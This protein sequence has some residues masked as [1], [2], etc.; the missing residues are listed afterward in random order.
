MAEETNPINPLDPLGPEYGSMNAPKLDLKSMLPFEG[1]NINPNIVDIPYDPL[2]V[3]SFE[4]RQDF[5]IK[6]K[7]TGHLYKEKPEKNP[8]LD[9]KAFTSALKAKVYNRISANNS[10]DSYARMYSYDAGPSGQNFYKRYAAFGNETFERI[11]F[12]PTRNNEAIYNEGTSWLQRHTRMLQYSAAPL[13]AA[14]FTS[15]PR[16]LMRMLKGDFSTDPADAKIYAEA[17]AIGQDTAGGVG[18]FMNNLSMNFAYTAGIMTEAIVEEAVGALLAAPTGGASFAA[19]TINNARKIP[20]IFRALGKAFKGMTT[21][22]AFNKTLNAANDINTARKM[23]SWAKIEKGVSSKVGRFINPAE[24]TFEAIS[25][26]IKNADNLQGLARAYNTAYKTAGG[27]YRDVRAINMAL[28]EARL[29][30]GFT[31]NEIYNDL[32]REFYDKNGFAPDNDM[33]RDMRKQALE[34]GLDTL[35][36][37]AWLIYLSNKIVFPNIVG[38]RGG[39][40]SFL[41]SKTDDILDLKFGKVKKT[42]VP[43]SEGSKIMTPKYEWVENSFKNTI[44]ETYKQPLRKLLPAMG[45]YFKANVTEGL[46][47]NFQ[48]IIAEA[49]K[50]YYISTFQNPKKDSTEYY[51]GLM[52]T[53]FKEHFQTTGLETFA[54]G[55]FMGFLGGGMNKSF[56]YL[57]QAVNYIKDKDAY[58]EYKAAK[59]TYGAKIA[60]NLSSIDV[61]EFFDNRAFNF[62]EQLGTISQEAL[63]KKVARDQRHKQFVGQLNQVLDHNMMEMFVNHLSSYKDLT[64]EEFQEALGFETIEEATAAQLKIDSTIEKALNVQKRYDSFKERYPDPINTKEMSRLESLGKDSE[65]YQNAQFLNS[66]WRLSRHN[67]VFFG[68]S[69]EDALQRMSKIVNKVVNNGP[70]GDANASDVSILFDPKKMYQ[71][72][73]MLETEIK[74]AEDAGEVNVDI[75]NKRNKL[76]ALKEVIEKGDEYAKY[77][78]TNETL[79]E[80]LFYSYLRL[81]KELTDEELNEEVKKIKEGVDEETII[82]SQNAYENA[83]KNYLKVIGKMSDSD[84]F[85]SQVDESFEDLLDFYKLQDEKQA[86]AKAVNMLNDPESF[87]EHVERNMAWMKQL[88]NNRKDYY[89]DMVNNAM[90]STLANDLINSLASEGIYI[91]A[92]DLENLVNYNILP[93]EFYDDAKKIVIKRNNPRYKE[94]A[95]VLNY[96]IQQKNNPV[97]KSTGSEKLDAK[98]QELDNKMKA[99]LEKLSKEEKRVDLDPVEIKK[100]STITYKALLNKIEPG[101]YVD[102]TYFE[103]GEEI[104]ATFYRTEEGFKF[105]NDQ[106]AVVPLGNRTRISKAQPFELRMVPNEEEAKEVIERYNKLKEEAANQINEEEFEEAPKAPLTTLDAIQ[107]DAPELYKQLQELYEESLGGSEE[108][109]KIEAFE[110]GEGFERFIKINSQARKLINEH[111]AKSAVKKSLGDQEI[112][113]KINYKGVETDVNQIPENELKKVLNTREIYLEGLEKEEEPNINLIATVKREIA[114]IKKVLS[115]LKTSGLTPQQQQVVNELEKLGAQEFDILDG[116]YIIDGDMY[117]RVS[118]IVEKLSGKTYKY[119][120]QDVL[121]TLMLKVFKGK[122]F[123]KK[124]VEELIKAIED[125]V[126]NVSVTSERLSGFEFTDRQGITKDVYDREVK[127]SLEK[128]KEK[129]DAL[130]KSKP[131]APYKEVKQDIINIVAENT[132]EEARIIGNYIDEA[133]RDFFSGVQPKF[134]PAR[135]TQ[136]AY[137]FLFGDITTTD[138]EGNPIKTG[139]LTQLKKLIENEGLYIYSKGI[140]LYDTNTKIAGTI[141][142]ILVDRSGNAYIV[143]VKTGKSS[144]WAHFTKDKLKGLNKTKEELTKEDAYSKVENYVLQQAI[145]SNLLYNMTGIDSSISLL[146]IEQETD[147]RTAKITSIKK[148]SVLEAGKARINLTRD[149]RLTTDEKTAGEKV[150][151]AVPRIAPKAPPTAGTQTGQSTQDIE[152]KKADI[153][154][155]RQRDLDLVEHENDR[156]KKVNPEGENIPLTDLE[157]KKVNAQI[158]KILDTS[159]TVEEAQERI[160]NIRIGGQQLV[161]RGN[162][163]QFFNTFVEERISGVTEETFEEFRAPKTKEQVNAKYDAELA[164][165]EGKPGETTTGKKSKETLQAEALAEEILKD[166][167]KAPM[168]WVLQKSIE[169]SKLIDKLSIEKAQEVSNALDKRFSELNSDPE[170]TS[171]PSIS[172][173]KNT[174][175]IVKDTIFKDKAKTKVFAT[176]GDI[177]AV[178]KINEKTGKVTVKVKT[179]GKVS[180]QTFTLEELDNLFKL[181]EEMGKDTSVKS[182]ERT[183]EEKNNINES[184]KTTSDFLSDQESLDQT[185]KEVS[186]KT[187]TDTENDILDDIGC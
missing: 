148:S 70:L 182:V 18:A 6:D 159:K 154:R 164:A 44:K 31:Q 21:A 173:K 146:P 40:K 158:N 68:E 134:D 24:N 128:V 167:S 39:L 72:V 185:I 163:R 79:K 147:A 46:Q 151:E 155:R 157:L 180:Q 86:M 90:N 63:T 82:Q 183:T 48:E 124:T 179:D 161:F 100:G 73:D 49:S 76:N 102:V 122:T 35:Y 170:N 127:T 83:Y 135:I 2:P 60:A 98:I 25:A 142:L 91:S 16:S 97:G 7:V 4:P 10:N 69:Y 178:Y 50:K 117:T 169:M 175:L 174:K 66:A 172:I 145:Y 138:E 78:M 19:A 62:S 26:S 53:A 106:G 103:K 15:G 59:K 113:L 55:F 112:S 94:Y 144:K 80:R 133:I 27:F 8:N 81:G 143:D 1:Q 136:E 115:Q 152:A 17:S 130:L 116:K 56:D 181:Y 171:N 121:E 101:T 153:E 107:K 123:N 41:S 65:E 92:E 105:D 88:Y 30:G 37:N 29:E 74:T 156:L 32:Y 85:D 45:S 20:K 87:V 52:K 23:W 5:N 109:S 77:N 61:K 119:S 111:N 67:A 104:E 149:Y 114:T 43:K 108:A 150:D 36:K 110:Y 71:E 187:S 38:P 176:Q 13:F 120:S 162:D 118:N 126:A 95:Q 166:V 58:R 47:E 22:N 131:D 3:S 57:S 75:I 129:L 177:A 14:G 54:S 11:G 84:V 165:L 139:Y 96:Y 160:S 42:M 89:T 137:D 9:A 12:S 186:N 125:N 51:N 64:P 93:E 184:I 99:E 33:Q 141:D 140:T 168:S 28:A 34:G 132:Y